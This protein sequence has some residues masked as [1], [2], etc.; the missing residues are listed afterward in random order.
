M[1][2]LRL[3]AGD[4]LGRKI[5]PRHQKGGHTAYDDY[6][7]SKRTYVVEEVY[8]YYVRCREVVNEDREYIDR[9]CFNVGDL[10]QMGIIRSVGQRESSLQAKGIREPHG[11]SDYERWK[12]RRW[13]N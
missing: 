9:A 4:L 11:H 6:I 3:F 7:M 8:P 13:T 5:K 12:E 1:I 10:V 2:D